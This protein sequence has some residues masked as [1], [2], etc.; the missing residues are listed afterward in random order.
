[1]LRLFVAV[2]VAGL[3]LGAYGLATDADTAA[4]AGFAAAAA[5]ALCGFL[6]FA[7]SRWGKAVLARALLRRLDLRGDERMLD[8]GCGSGV[9]LVTAAA[10]LPWGRGVGV[11]RWLPR[12]QR[13]SDPETCRHNAVS[14]GVADRVRVV[15]GDM[16][17]LPFPSESFDLVV[18]SLSI[19]TLR[20]RPLRRAA[21]AEAVRVLR[22]G[23]TLL[24]LDFTY[25]SQYATDAGDAGLRDVRRSRPYGLVF[26]P[27]RTVT[28]VK[29]MAN[30]QGGN[31][32]SEGSV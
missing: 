28:G 16:T 26:P 13:G 27:V 11:D 17:D 19:Q 30:G 23:G 15:T 32:E 12:H 5:A 31:P 20:L 29:P 7:G 21:L 3:A 10:L 8:V 25:T 9:M 4:R 14:L 18:A 22:P 1:M 24:I 6:Q 2:T